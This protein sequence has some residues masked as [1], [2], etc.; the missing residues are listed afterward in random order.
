[1]ADAVIVDGTAGDD[2]ISLVSDNGSIVVKGLAEQVTI[3]NAD[4][5]DSLIINGLGGNDVIDASGLRAGQIS[6]LTI[7]GGDGD[8][9]IKGSAGNDTVIGGRGNDVALLGAGN[10]A[11]VWNPGDGSDVVE[12]QAGFDTLQ[13]NG[14]NVGENIDISANGGRARL[15]RDVGNV[16]MDLNSVERINVAAVGGAD[17]ITVNDLTRTAVSLVALDLSATPGTGVGDGQQD[18]VEINATGGADVINITYNNGVVTV[19]GLAAEVTIAGFDATDRLV[20]NGLG[21]NDIINAAGLGGAMQ[22]FANGGDGNDVLI[23]GVGIDTLAGGAGDDILIG[24]G[25]ARRTRRRTGRQR[26]R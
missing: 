18:T 24:G 25:G 15:F 10:D 4:A 7:N 6:N 16:T 21:G 19:S 22:F 14:A 17:A 11:F 26:R 1:L 23:G 20:I 5:G 12:G 8:D 9:A 3:A 2:R 13:F